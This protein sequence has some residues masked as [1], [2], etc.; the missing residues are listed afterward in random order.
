MAKK[1]QP[2]SYVRINHPKW[3]K[4]SVIYQINTRQF[5]PQGTFAAATDQLP[6]LKE[7]GVDILWLMPIH[8]IG[9]LHRKG[10]LG[11][12]YAVKDYFAVNPEF[13]TEADLR[14]FIDA[15]HAQ[16]FKVI[17]DWVA[18]HTAW[19][20]KLT[21]KHPDW[22]IKDWNGSF[23]STHGGIGMTSSISTTRCLQSVVT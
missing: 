23:R 7:L 14:H 8:P 6:R 2:T 16:G 20:N 13:G 15:A 21:V 9:E 4:K 17:L 1:F 22:Y 12:P 18:N 11:S 3:A 5:T 19:D 10:S